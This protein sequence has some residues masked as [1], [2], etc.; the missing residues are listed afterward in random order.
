MRNYEEAK[1]K[2]IEK[3]EKLYNE[4]KDE[5]EKSKYKQYFLLE[6]NDLYEEFQSDINERYLRYLKKIEPY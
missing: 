1:Q 3:Y 4:A 6:F 5:E 2:L